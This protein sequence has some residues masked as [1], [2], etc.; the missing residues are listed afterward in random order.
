MIILGVYDD[1]INLHIKNYPFSVNEMLIRQLLSHPLEFKVEDYLI[2]SGTLRVLIVDKAE[3]L[4]KVEGVAYM[5]SDN[6]NFEE[7]TE[8][9]FLCLIR[10]M[11]P[12]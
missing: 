12:I 9:Q 3:N 7:I 4:I 6:G 10:I 2:E 8:K 5:Y 11:S 1:G